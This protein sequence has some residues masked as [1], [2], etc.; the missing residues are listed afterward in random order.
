LF[1]KAESWHIVEYE[2]FRNIFPATPFILMYRHPG[3]VLNSHIKRRGSI[4]VPG[5][6]SPALFNL[7]KEDLKQYSLDEYLCVVLQHLIN[8]MIIVL[9]NDKR[10][11]LINYSEGPM[12]MLNK[13]I[14]ATGLVIEAA[15]FNKMVQ[16]V[17]YH[18]KYPSEKFAEEKV[19]IAGNIE[20]E[21]A[22]VLYNQ[23]VTIKN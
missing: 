18:S 20:L 1:I 6:F 7:T 10:S 5:V 21:K 8:K 14:K 17:A 23:M 13:V 19:Q 9:Q 22:I 11:F 3:E 4:A 12:V 2:L 16:R 15:M